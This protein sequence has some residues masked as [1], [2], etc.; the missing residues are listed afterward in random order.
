MFKAMDRGG[1][2]I[3]KTLF[4]NLLATLQHETLTH[5][6]LIKDSFHC[7]QQK[8]KMRSSPFQR[9]PLVHGA[10]ITSASEVSNILL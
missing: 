8:V 4:I 1:G 7:G 9:P 5:K 3:E 6:P 10:L 2:G